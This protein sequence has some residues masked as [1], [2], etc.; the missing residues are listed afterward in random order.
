MELIKV[1]K[2]IKYPDKKD[3]SKFVKEWL[4]AKKVGNITINFYKGGISSIKFEET[5][6]T[7]FLPKA[8]IEIKKIL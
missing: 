5:I 7:V 2:E 4:E 6:K 8:G 1:R 3:I